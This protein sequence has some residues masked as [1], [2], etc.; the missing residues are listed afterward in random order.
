MVGNSRGNSEV[1]GGKERLTTEE[2]GNAG[3]DATASV[4]AG[5]RGFSRS[6]STEASGFSRP[7]RLTDLLAPRPA[8]DGLENARS[9]TFQWV[10]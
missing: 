2:G 7:T 8:S 1:N 3:C 5:F 6:S 9:T 10:S 4:H